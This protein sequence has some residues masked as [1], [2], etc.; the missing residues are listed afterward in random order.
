VIQDVSTIA[1]AETEP[2]S[3]GYSFTNDARILTTT[4]NEDVRLGGLV[5]Q[6][7]ETLH[8]QEATIE[9]TLE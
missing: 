9:Y 3:T 4:I 5:Q 2:T 6:P 8:R 7:Q 1:A